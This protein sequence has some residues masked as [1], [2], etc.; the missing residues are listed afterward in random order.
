MELAR[1]GSAA[2][3]GVVP[4]YVLVACVVEY[5]PRHVTMANSNGLMK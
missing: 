2:V 4:A 1:L 3:C 5:E